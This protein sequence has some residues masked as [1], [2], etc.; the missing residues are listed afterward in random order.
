MNPSLKN[1]FLQLRLLYYMI[2]SGIVV[3]GIAL[4]ISGGMQD[5]IPA[6]QSWLRYAA[7][8]SGMAMLFLA[9]RL[10]KTRLEEARNQTE[11]YKKLAHYRSALLVRYLVLDGAA[12]INLIGFYLSGDLL[13]FFLA[14]VVLLLFVLYRP[15]VAKLC[16]DLELNSAEEQIIYGKKEK[17]E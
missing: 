14:G 2:P 7:P 11:L 13:F 1:Y 9:H 4:W 12:I 6:G 10:F 8:V 16:K 15:T 5:E 3:M 17:P